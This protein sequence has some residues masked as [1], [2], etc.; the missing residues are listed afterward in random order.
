LPVLGEKNM[1]FFNWGN[2]EWVY[3]A[4]S[5]GSLNVMNVGIV[6]IDPGKRQNKHVHY[7]DE[8]LLYVISGKGR[9]QVGDEIHTIKAGSIHHI[10]SGSI[11]ETMN[12]ELEPIVEL[13][14]SIPAIQKKNLSLYK[15]GEMTLNYESLVENVV[16]D[17]KN[18]SELRGLY[19]SAFG[20]MEI[21]VAVFNKDGG[22]VIEGRN[23]PQLC[24]TACGV[25]KNKGKCPIYQ[26]QN[27]Y[28]PPIYNDSSAYIC[29]FGLTVLNVPIVVN[30]TAIGWIKG[31]HI[32]TYRNEFSS[33]ENNVQQG[34]LHKE[35][36]EDMPVLPKSRVN[37]I[38]RI[39]KDMA[40]NIAE[41]SVIKNTK[42]ELGKKERLIK[43][44]AEN[45]SVLEESLKMVRDE[46]LDIQINNHFLF[47]TLNAIASMAVQDNSMKTYDAVI[48]LSNMFRYSLRNKSSSILLKDEIEYLRNYIA[49]QQLRYGDN[50]RVDFD[51]PEE[52]ANVKIPFNC[53]QPIVGNSFKHGFKNKKREIRIEIRVEPGERCMK[54]VIEDNGMGMEKNDL[55]QL[56]ERLKEGKGRNS[57]WMMIY[58][59]LR[60]FYGE[61]FTIDIDNRPEG[62]IRVTLLLPV[63]AS[64]R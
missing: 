35:L 56:L 62:G 33:S 41:Y 17:G 61:K 48:E 25:H 7:G 18:N 2:I 36:F 64:E 11:H 59:K 21:P 63:I 58:S 37:A 50:L 31:G 13:I 26:I 27:E 38:M 40:K 39:M 4:D 23:Y 24:K 9:Q 3:E 44:I 55:E 42:T 29:P 47:N 53:L 22:N 6:T 10:E 45:E 12:I 60:S 20:S 8:Q 5:I 34:E 30:Q 51:I 1:Q 57:G 49:L 52:L 46:V 32:R 19:E 28:A 15:D 54:L 14:I 16:S 43:E